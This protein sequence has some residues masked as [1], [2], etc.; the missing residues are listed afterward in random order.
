MHIVGSSPEL[1]VRWVQFGVFM[2]RF[3]IH[4]WNDDGTANEPWMHA[5]ATPL[6]R[7]EDGVLRPASWPA[8]SVPTSRA[9]C[10]RAR[11]DRR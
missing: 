8:A 1:L 4:S 7:D 3:S 11:M 6:V 9:A 5:E 2:P 10:L